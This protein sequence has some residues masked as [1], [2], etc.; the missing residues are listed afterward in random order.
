MAVYLIFYPGRG[1]SFA[2]HFLEKEDISGLS[3]EPKHPGNN[4]GC[5]QLSLAQNLGSGDLAGR[6]VD[7]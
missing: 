4:R 3:H 7:Y 1:R 2:P 6:A 5:P